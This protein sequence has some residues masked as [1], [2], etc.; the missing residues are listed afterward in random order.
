M[1]IYFPTLTRRGCGMLG[2]KRER[3][4]DLLSIIRFLFPFSSDLQSSPCR[5]VAREREGW[6]CRGPQRGEGG[7]EEGDIITFYSRG[8][9]A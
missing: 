3:R 9:R 6:C 2:D 5:L 7:Q 4:A 8:S 1:L